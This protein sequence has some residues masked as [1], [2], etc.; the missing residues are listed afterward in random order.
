MAPNSSD[1]K[2]T[3]SCSLYIHIPFCRSKC[4]YCDFYSLAGHDC[5]IDEYLDCIAAEW[6]L[7][8]RSGSFEITSL[9]I[10]GGTPSLI[11]ADRWSRF[12][13]EFFSTLPLVPN[14]EWTVECNPDSFSEK[15]LDVLSSS[16]VNR[17][18][19]GI[20]SLDDRLL[21]FAGRA[22]TAQQALTILGN[23]ALE[24]IDSTG[25]DLM[26]GLPGQTPQSFR[27]SLETALDQPAVK[28]LSAYELTISPHTPFG[29]H[30][31]T[32]PLPDEESIC[33]MAEILLQVTARKGLEHY[34]VS[35]FA[36]QGFRCRHN[37]AYWDHSPWIGLGCAAHSY[38]HPRRFWNVASIDH[39]M[40]KLKTDSFPLENE[41]LIYPDTL[42]REMILLGLRRRDGINELFFEKRTGM[43]FTER[44]GE[45]LLQR[46]VERQLLKYNPP[47]WQP[48]ERG[49]LCAD[50]M[51][52]ELF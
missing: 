7:Y 34:E 37:C 24:R 3:L 13:S 32:L 8:E 14:A 12:S 35:N 4:R 47:W 26:Y 38:I 51:A 25:V 2:S 49:M 21:R 31:R 39:Y 46:F 27:H 9:Y 15:L 6:R 10:G 29:R 50:Y 16:G 11:S 30:H 40:N 41:E 45:K 22:H 23:P 52:R 1:T 43:K 42:A 18:T 20:Q 5:L 28:H 33:R 19:F 36:K 17:L 44:A 48:T